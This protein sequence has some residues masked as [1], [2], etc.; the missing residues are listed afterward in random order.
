MRIIACR[1]ISPDQSVSF[2]FGTELE[3]H[4]DGFQN[5]SRRAS[6]LSAWS[7][8]HYLLSEQN[9]CPIPKVSFTD[10]GKPFFVDS[11]LH[12][13]ISHSGSMCAVSLAD[14]KTGV[15]IEL[16]RPTYS[17]SLI[18]RTLS[19]TEAEV[20]DGDFTALWCRKECLVKMSGS[21]IS[22]YPSKINTLEDTVS[23][24]EKSIW[25]STMRE[26]R[27]SAVFEQKSNEPVRYFLF[28]H[29]P[30]DQSNLL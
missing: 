26:Y 24:A 5:P 15:D 3:A 9:I 16:V 11:P 19:E 25:D 6:S 27:M 20:F 17:P 4:L 12:F 2:D 21:G 7:L 28:H 23:F 13:S 22:E 1:E 29:P 18:R 14:V 8:L 10:R 30:A